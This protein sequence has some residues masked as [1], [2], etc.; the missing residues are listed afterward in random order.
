MIFLFSYCN[1]QEMLKD[2]PREKLVRDHVEFYYDVWQKHARLIKSCVLA[3][4]EFAKTVY[5]KDGDMLVKDG[6]N[7]QLA[8]PVGGFHFVEAGSIE[9]VIE[10]AKQYP[11]PEGFASLEIRP[12]GNLWEE[13]P[14]LDTAAPAA[15]VWRLY[16]DVS[17][18]PDWQENVTGVDLDV[19]LETGASGTLHTANRGA[20]PLRITGAKQ[21]AWFA[22]EVD[23]ADGV[24]MQ[25]GHELVPLPDGGTRIKHIAT[26]PRA[27]LDLMGMEFRLAFN[28]ETR[29]SMRALAERATAA[30]LATKQ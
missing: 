8:M 19:G 28:D 12:V 21:D 16:S 13:T 11:I 27:T 15:A 1:D 24:T 14:E 2:T 7:E 29:A 9:E 6:P 3:P 10:V 18:W 23:Y 26:I 5:P 30:E 20:L 22:A 4:P 25:L 17:T